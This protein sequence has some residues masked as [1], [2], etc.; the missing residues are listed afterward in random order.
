MNGSAETNITLEPARVLLGWMDTEDALHA[1]HGG[2]ADVE[3]SEA[4]RERLRIAR[5]RVA[6]RRVGIDQRNLITPVPGTLVPYMNDL[7]RHPVTEKLLAEGWA[8][9]VVD[10]RRLCAFQPR[11][12]TH[13][14]D[15]RI[16]TVDPGDLAS[17]AAVSLPMPGTTTA[18]ACFD[19]ARNAWIMTS[20]DPNLRVT[21]NFRQP[22]GTQVGFGFALSLG[23][24]FLSVIQHAG[25][26]FLADGYHRAVA[27]LQ[28]GITHVPAMTHTIPDGE[29]FQLPS[30]MLPPTAYHGDRPPQLTDFFAAD[31]SIAVHLPV[32]RRIIIIQALEVMA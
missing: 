9:S 28:R 22:M 26:Y 1:Q 4:D 30:G 2:V 16:S 23:S 8:P 17:L 19:P 14:A 31:V 10:L 24:S 18:P 11:V 7:R 15:Q 5:E 13:Q 20:S 6:A 29:P 27:F 32:F 12:F 25:R 3:T 21:G